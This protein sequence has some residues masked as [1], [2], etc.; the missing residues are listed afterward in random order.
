MKNEKLPPVGTK[1]FDLN[2]GHGVISFIEPLDLCPIDVIFENRIGQSYTSNGKLENG[3]IPTLSLTEYDFFKGGFTPMSEWNKPKVGDVGYFW[4]NENW[5]N[6]FYSA[7]TQINKNADSPY[8][9]IPG[10]LFKNFTPEVPDWYKAKVEEIRK[11]LK[12]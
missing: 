11:G 5:D 9:S 3:I 8:T 10:S 4:D 6:L 7:I 1:V 12:K 2:Y